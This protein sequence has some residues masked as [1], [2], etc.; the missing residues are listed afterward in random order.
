MDFQGSDGSH[1]SLAVPIDVSN[2]TVTVS[3]R[4]ASGRSPTRSVPTPA[5]VSNLARPDPLDTSS[6]GPHDNLSARR[7]SRRSP[8]RRPLLTYNV[9]PYPITG[10]FEPID[11]LP[12]INVANAGNSVPVKF[13]LSGFR[14]STCSLRLSSFAADDL[15]RRRAI[16]SR[17]SRHRAGAGFTYDPVLDRY[18]YNWKTERS[19]KSTCRQLIVRLRD[20]TEKRANFRFKLLGQQVLVAGER[21]EHE[22]DVLERV[23]RVRRDAEVRVAL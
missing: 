4:T 12:I 2:P 20:G 3:R 15:R 10:F 5:R 21:L 8:V 18:K 14:A 13:S 1:G 6:V 16:R 11:N 9:A 17:R 22:V 19:W 23:V 7:G